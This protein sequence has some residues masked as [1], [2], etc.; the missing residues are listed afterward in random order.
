MGSLDSLTHINSKVDRDTKNR[1]KNKHR[2]ASV[3]VKK[4][5]LKYHFMPN[6]TLLQL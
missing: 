3:V 5:I 2:F 6:T 1:E 4:Y